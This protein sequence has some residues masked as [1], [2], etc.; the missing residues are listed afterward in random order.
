MDF[1]GNHFL[2]N[3]GVQ[4][5]KR[6]WGDEVTNWETPDTRLYETSIITV[7]ITVITFFIEKCT[8]T[9]RGQRGSVPTHYSPGLSLPVQF[10]SD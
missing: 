7:I 6:M 4:S 5:S 8:G 1:V 3:S 9:Q 2:F 10:M